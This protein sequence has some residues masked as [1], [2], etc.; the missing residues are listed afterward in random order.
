MLLRSIPRLFFLRSS[1]RHRRAHRYRRLTMLAIFTIAALLVTPF[2][3]IYK[4]PQFLIRYLQHRWPDV[5]FHVPTSSKLVALTIDDGPSQYTSELAN[6]LKENDATAT[7]FIIGGQVPGREQVLRDLVQNGNELANHAMHD[8]TSKAL[9]EDA[10]REQIGAVQ[11]MIQQA[12]AALDPK[13]EYPKYFRPGGGFFGARM[14]KLLGQLG[15]RLVLGDIYPH[16]PFVPYWRVNAKHILSMLHP[17]GIIICHDRRSWTLPMLRKVLPEIRR[18][19]YRIVTVTE[20][21][22][23]T[24]RR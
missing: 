11:G 6:I 3:F 5:L 23:S 16:D 2:Y 4:P 14:Q 10:L 20:L 17:G 15:Y 21:L 18:R 8:E 19:G 12:Y 22:E 13:R 9:S 24:K 7:W 1:F